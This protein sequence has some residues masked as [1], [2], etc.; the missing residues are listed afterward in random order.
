M[1][2]QHLIKSKPKE[3]QV[4]NNFILNYWLGVRLVGG[5]LDYTQPFKL[6]VYL[7]LTCEESAFLRCK[8]PGM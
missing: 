2:T 4:N 6:T 8:P 5:V 7:C 3:G 1:H